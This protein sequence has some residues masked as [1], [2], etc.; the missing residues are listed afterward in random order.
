MEKGR[1]TC[2]GLS[3]AARIT[4]KMQR[5]VQG[6]WVGEQGSAGLTGKRVG[7]GVVAAVGREYNRR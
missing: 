7:C 4:E 2:G 5:V 3:I 1:E 6:R